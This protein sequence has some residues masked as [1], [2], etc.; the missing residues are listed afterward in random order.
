MTP[1]TK[2]QREVMRLTALLPRITS[3]NTKQA[4]ECFY[5]VKFT[6][7]TKAW[8][9]ECGHEF[10]DNGNHVC[11]H[12]HTRFDQTEETRKK[13]DGHNRAYFVILDTVEGWQVMRYIRVDKKSIA[14][15][16][17]EWH[18]WE[19]M[20]LWFTQGHYEVVA[21]YKGM[22]MYVDS[23]SYGS[24]LEIR[25]VTKSY[26]GPLTIE[27]I[28]YSYI[29]KRSIL[30]QLQRI[31]F[32]TEH[33]Q[34]MK[35]D[36]KDIYRLLLAH[37]MAE[38]LFKQGHTEILSTM[39]YRKCLSEKYF[40]AVKIALRNHYK[41]IEENLSSWLDMVDSLIYLHKD[42]HNAFYVCPKDFTKAHDRWTKL[43][44]R[45]ARE[46]AKL[47]E[48]TKKQRALEREKE[49]ID[50]YDT[51]HM[52]FMGFKL[53]DGTVVI[54]VLPNVEAFKEDAAYMHHCVY[55]NGYW[56]KPQSLIMSA[57][58][59]GQ[60]EETIEVDLK[61]LK[62]VQSRGKYNKPTPYHD[63]IVKLVEK[64][65]NKIRKVAL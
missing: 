28:P 1:R 33:D 27:D 35:F 55:T 8:C 13:V 39:N 61:R 49:A 65:M 31:E 11:P 36:R 44:Y 58:V 40:I 17:A 26:N 18:L 21:R 3:R 16:K 2:A 23:F 7:G 30:P 12:C 62:L 42:I 24:D 10:V 52:K 38:T 15:S 57:T 64:N 46:R 20:Q 59:N 29:E 60:K 47:A 54:K 22:G 19:V 41:V 25:N 6:T 43:A 63:E 4:R 53:S 48:R 14:G 45:K 5:K 9:S 56:K 32:D 50:K 37:P 34:C 51:S